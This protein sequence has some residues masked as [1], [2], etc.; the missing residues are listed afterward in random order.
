MFGVEY[1]TATRFVRQVAPPSGESAYTRHMLLL[2]P[3]LVPDGAAA[4]NRRAGSAAA[5]VANP[6]CARH[7]PSA[8]RTMARKPP[9][10]RALGIV[11]QQDWPLAP[12]TLAADGGAGRGYWL[13]ADPVHL[14]VM[15]DR[16]VLADSSAF[17]LSQQE[18]DALVASIGQHFGDALRPLPLHPTRWYLQFRAVRRT[19]VT[20][21]LSVA[22]GRD[23]EPLLPQGDDA[24]PCGCS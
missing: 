12:I 13:R 19:C 23:I 1:A 24:R 22:T 2:V 5:R 3:A 7:P 8:V 6:A 11:R 17:E 14:R 20:T 15:R 9:C 18:A 4:R 21:P 10:A 16:I